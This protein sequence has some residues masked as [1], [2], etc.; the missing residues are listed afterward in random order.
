MSSSYLIRYLITWNLSV[1]PADRQSVSSVPTLL[2]NFASLI[3]LTYLI[4][5]VFCLLK[6]FFHFVNVAVPDLFGEVVHLI[7]KGFG[8]GRIK[9]LFVSFCPVANQTSHLVFNGLGN[10]VD[11]LLFLLLFFLR[12]HKFLVGMT[13]F[14]KM[15]ILRPDFI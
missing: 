7:L 14:N 11:Q 15:K 2:P 1:K 8:K 10:K 5:S 6:V 3:S 4:F 13:S 9:R 12:I